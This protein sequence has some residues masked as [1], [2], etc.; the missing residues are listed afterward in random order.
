MQRLDS[1]H[2]NS[3]TRLQ[4]ISAKQ[5]TWC[6]WTVI[7]KEL[8]HCVFI[9]NVARNLL[10]VT[11]L[12]SMRSEACS[13]FLQILLIISSPDD[14][15]SQFS[16][17]RAYF[18]YTVWHCTGQHC[19]SM[20]ACTYWLFASMWRPLVSVIITLDYVVIIFHRQMWYRSLSLHIFA[21]IKVRHHPHPL[22]YLCAKFYFFCG[23]HCWASPQKIVYSIIHPPSLSDALG[24]KAC[25][26][27]LVTIKLKTI[28]TKNEVDHF[29]RQMDTPG[30]G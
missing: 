2:P 13:K 21:K 3:P 5:A 14:Y 29:C 11:Q 25:A 8:C 16:I 20:Y 4:S 18:V 6:R 12:P 1:F 15:R 27:E 26:S 9:A 19:S 28:L 24:T 10:E 17:P 22:G 23:L 7:G 30:I